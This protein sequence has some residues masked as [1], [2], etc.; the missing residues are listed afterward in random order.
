MYNKNHKRVTIEILFMLAKVKML[1]TI[2]SNN[3]IE[4]MSNLQT[5]KI[6]KTAS[7]ERIKFTFSKKKTIHTFTVIRTSLNEKNHNMKIR[8]TSTSQLKQIIFSQEIIFNQN[9]NSENYN[10]TQISSIFFFEL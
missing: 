9:E 4:E 2:T 8:H 3:S 5:K 6:S 10:Q 7:E 1:T